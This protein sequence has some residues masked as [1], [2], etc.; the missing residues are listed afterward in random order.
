M[1][2]D[3]KVTVGATSTLVSAAKTRKGIT[4][5]NDSAAVIYVSWG[6][7]AV[8]NQGDR[9][10]ANGGSVTRQHWHGEV[11]AITSPAGGNLCGSEW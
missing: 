9:L 4:L 5:V 3:I 10:N 11:Y 7:P 6:G 2:E 8:M 1:H